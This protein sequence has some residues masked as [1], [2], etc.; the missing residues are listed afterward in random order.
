MAER[1][2]DEPAEW[3]SEDACA[4]LHRFHGIRY[5]ESAGFR[6]QSV[7]HT[8]VGVDDG[9]ETSVLRAVHAGA[10]FGGIVGGRLTFDTTGLD[11]VMTALFVVIFVDQWMTT[12]RKSHM[13]ALTGIVVPVI[14]L[15][16]FGADNFMIPSLIAMLVMFIVLRPYLDDLKRDDAD[17]EVV[18]A[19]RNE[20]GKVR[21]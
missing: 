3:G 20:V 15:A 7:R 6:I 21:S 1:N 12:R 2:A 11:F 14:C 4:H 8:Y 5:S 9:N 19:D 17:G 18:A 16:L 13:A 10:T